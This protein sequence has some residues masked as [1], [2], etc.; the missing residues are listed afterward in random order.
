MDNI[1]HAFAARFD[2]SHCG[3]WICIQVNLMIPLDAEDNWVSFV[4]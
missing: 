2:G 4:E 1:A 3:F